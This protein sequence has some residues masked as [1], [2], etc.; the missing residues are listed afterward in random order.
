MFPK[1]SALLLEG[2]SLS[3][4][5]PSSDSSNVMVPLSGFT[6]FLKTFEY[7]PNTLSSSLNGESS[8]LKILSSFINL[9]KNSLSKEELYLVEGIVLR[10]T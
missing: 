4:D 5:K 10:T 8:I 1:Y 6:F 3:K 9:L 2:F 7:S